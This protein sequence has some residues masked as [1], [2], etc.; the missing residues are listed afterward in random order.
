MKPRNKTAS[1]EIIHRL[2]GRAGQ[3]D[4]AH[5]SHLRFALC[6]LAL[7]A[8]PILF[9][10]SC[11]A[12]GNKT[13]FTQGG[14]GSTS[15]SMSTTNS[16]VGGGGG[17]NFTTS[18]TGTGSTGSGGDPTTCAE[19][20]ASRTYIG[21]DFWPTVVANN[22]WSIFDYAVVVANAG[23]QPADVTV[24]RKGQQVATAQVAP[25]SLQTVYLPWVP[26][27]KG[28][29]ADSCGQSMP[30]SATVRSNGG[31]YHLT[32]TVP[33]TVYQF[34][35]L[36]YQGQGGPPG[37]DWSSCPGINGCNGFPIGCYSFSNDA[38]LL[39]PSTAMTGN[40]RITAQSDWTPYIGGYFAVTGTQDGTN[41]TVYLA[42]GGYVVGGGG[43]AT[44]NGGGTITF[45][46][47]AGDVVELVS[48]TNHD[49][50]GTLIKA[51][52][53][54]QVISGM[55]CLDQ[56]FGAQACDHVEETVFPA[57]TLGKH[58]FVTVP[59]SPHG[60]GVGHMVRIVG[61]VDGT[62]LTYPSGTKPAGAPTTIN[63]GQVVDL[64]QVGDNFEIEGDH[65]FAVVSFL[66]G[67]SIVDPNTQIPN[68]QGDPSQSN[69][70]A[71][72]Q[73]RTKYVFLAPT[74]YARNYVDVIGPTNA[75]VQVDGKPATGPTQSIGSGYAIARISLGPGNNGAHVLTSSQ[76]VGIQ[77]VGYGSYTSYY[78]PGGLNLATIAPP[79]PPPN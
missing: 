19:A 38:S 29:D 25:N 42:S 28:P 40:Y 51:T 47:N 48:D 73:F 53:P 57:E 70:T 76:P 78:Y 8:T 3:D 18:T 39:L 59:T 46:L 31:A 67:A 60:V 45:S 43:V 23:D 14:G 41:V 77:V 7:T 34:N 13:G 49:N 54:V 12:G 11:S 37:K 2:H 44:T 36:E 24:T 71:V 62:T 17:I 30:L 26:E 61:N 32:T 56:P 72:E 65:E 9:A 22:V 74:D 58:Y 63:A 20:E 16:N 4:N 10:V 52:A 79:P 35:A 66:L 69:I 15:N 21:C 68:Q 55:P 33:V 64:G 50:T 27:L 75:S 1:S 5:M 6:G